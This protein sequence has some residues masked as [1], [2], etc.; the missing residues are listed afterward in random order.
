MSCESNPNPAAG[1]GEKG[2]AEGNN[3][4]KMSFTLS[5]ATGE[6]GELPPDHAVE[7]YL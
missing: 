7:A 4:V 5:I 3:Q 2:R 1:R 6:L